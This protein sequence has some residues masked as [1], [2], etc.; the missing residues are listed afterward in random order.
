M[1]I[2]TLL[3]GL[4][5]IMATTSGYA[6]TYKEAKKLLET[7]S[8]KMKS[9]DNLYLEFNYSLKNTAVEPPVTQNE[10]GNIA[11][12]GNDYHLNFLG[13]EQIRNGR[14]LYTILE[15]DEEVQV[16]TYDPEE[17]DQG[18]T[19]AR[20]LN[21]YQSGYSYKMGE[22]K[23]LQERTI[24]FVI[25]KPTASDIT[26]KIE[27]GIDKETL[28][29]YSLQQWDVNG[30]VTHFVVTQ[31]EPNKKFES[32]YFQFNRSQYSDYYIAE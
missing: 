12:K 30:S 5:V 27:V 22:T 2:R 16:T 29:V 13:T 20:I 1:K 9:F 25:L 14:K 10:Q 26:E 18:L 19:P 17:E 4:T 24:Q 21:L 3:L 8:Q 31:A 7:S 32:N 23:N 6:Q 15:A 11:I 28:I